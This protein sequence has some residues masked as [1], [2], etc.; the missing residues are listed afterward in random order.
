MQFRKTADIPPATLLGSENETN[1]AS[2]IFQY[3]FWCYHSVHLFLFRFSYR[4]GY[5]F[6]VT[7]WWFPAVHTGVLSRQYFRRQISVRPLPVTLT[8]GF[9][10]KEHYLLSVAK[11]HKHM[12]ELYIYESRLNKNTSVP[13]TS[14]KI[15]SKAHALRKNIKANWPCNQ[16]RALQVVQFADHASE[17]QPYLSIVNH[18][19]EAFWP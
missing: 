2:L 12:E 15:Y 11:G 10:Y 8:A 7:N 1:F 19:T 14:G 5:L 17:C 4:W 3:L 6:I 18:A 9:Y 13:W 16:W